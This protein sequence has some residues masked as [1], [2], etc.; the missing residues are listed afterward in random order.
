MN[1]DATDCRILNV[2]QRDGR[3]SVTDLA[4][5]VGLSQTPTLRRVR[6]LE[7]A[8]LIE[9][10]AARL[11]P[12]KLGYSVIVFASVYLERQ[13]LDIVDRFEKAIANIPQ[14][15]EAY[16]MAAGAEY[17]LRIV[18]HDLDW[19]HQFQRKRILSIPGV[20]KIDSSFTYWCIKRDVGLP[21]SV[22]AHG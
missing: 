2:L 1:L 11:D 9:G 12:R 4:E 7:D 16:S 8:G 21:V 5:K 19:Y 10:Y 14:V 18:A 15:I 20:A 13:S 17:L 22:S 3:I 6:Q